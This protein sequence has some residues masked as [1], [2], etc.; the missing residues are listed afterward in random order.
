MLIPL[1][2]IIVFSLNNLKTLNSKGD[3]FMAKLRCDYCGSFIEETMDTCINCGAVNKNRKRYA[4]TVPQSISEL[5]SWY[6]SQAV[7]PSNYIKFY[8]GMNVF[9]T[10]SIGIY[11]ENGEYIVYANTR[12]GRVI[13]YKGKDE[14]YAVH[15]L[16]IK[17]VE[18]I[19]FV[20]N[21]ILKQNERKNT[22]TGIAVVIAL[23]LV[24]FVLIPFIIFCFC[25]GGIF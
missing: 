21:S 7:S 24:I 8:I 14:A 18:C 4:S 20:H 15:E 11:E 12:D 10:G 1:L 16:Y 25:I 19:I 6:K 17:M 22:K 2:E 23:V 5:K 13:I 9:H 3:I